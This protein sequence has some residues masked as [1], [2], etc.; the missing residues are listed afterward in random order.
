MENLKKFD[1]KD[2]Q[3]NHYFSEFY[4]EPY[5]SYN[6]ETEEVLLTKQ[7]IYTYVVEGYYE[8]ANYGTSYIGEENEYENFLNELK[9]EYGNK[10]IELYL[11]KHD[12][13]TK[14]N[15][16]VYIRN[17]YSLTNKT[18]NAIHSY[19]FNYI[20]TT[21]DESGRSIPITINLEKYY[22]KYSFIKKIEQNELFPQ[23]Q[24]PP[25]EKLIWCWKAQGCEGFNKNHNTKYY[26]YNLPKTT[27]MNFLN[28]LA[29]YMGINVNDNQDGDSVNNLHTHNFIIY[30][31][32]EQK[33]YNIFLYDGYAAYDN[34]VDSFENNEIITFDT[35]TIQNIYLTDWT[36]LDDKGTFQYIDL[37]EFINQLP[38][39]SEYK[40]YLVQMSDNILR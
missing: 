15:V 4:I 40:N 13:N 5:C 21:T 37:T 3:L 24:E 29:N 32:N 6:L 19:F 28:D 30:F 22:R 17:D 25:Q 7:P 10:L 31:E 38:T 36:Y 27:F 16:K 2:E 23:M 9:N 18:D 20:H 35:T 33:S 1:T 8:D 39:D 26:Y 34:R 12:L 14:E 11:I